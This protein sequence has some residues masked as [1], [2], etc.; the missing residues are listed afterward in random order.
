[1]MTTALASD[2]LDRLGRR[3]QAAAA[4]IRPLRPGYRLTGRA[5]P[6]SVVASDEMPEEPYAGEMRAI[7]LLE[8]G[9]VPVYVTEAGVRAAVWGE[10]FSLAARARGALGAV[11]DGAIR[12]AD[13]VASLG[14]PVFCRGFSPLD[15][16]GRAVVDEIGGDVVCGGVLV[17]RGDYLV[18]DEDGVVFVP[19]ELADDVVARVEE[20]VRGEDGARSQLI[21]GKS[22]RDVWDTWGVL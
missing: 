15:T 14:L 20:K 1:M 6:V 21:A 2:A 10:L 16:M 11:V 4:T 19:A 17:R 8:P 7:E 13:A 18:A 3:E 22:V 9:D 5:L 12:D